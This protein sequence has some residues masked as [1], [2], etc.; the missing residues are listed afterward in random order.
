MAIYKKNEVDL[1]TTYTVEIDYY[2]DD[3]VFNGEYLKNEDGQLVYFGL[4]NVDG[5]Y[6]NKLSDV[7]LTNCITSDDNNYTIKLEKVDNT[8][9]KIFVNKP[10]KKLTL[11]KRKKSVSFYYTNILGKNNVL[12]NI[13]YHPKICHYSR[14]YNIYQIYKIS[15]PTFSFNNLYYVINYNGTSGVIDIDV[16]K[17]ASTIDITSNDLDKTFLHDD[18]FTHALPS[19]INNLIYTY[20]S[21]DHT[22]W[23]LYESGYTPIDLLSKHYDRIFSVNT[24]FSSLRGIFDYKMNRINGTF[25]SGDDGYVYFCAINHTNN[26]VVP[27]FKMNGNTIIERNKNVPEDTY[28]TYIIK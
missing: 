22:Y 8:A 10:K 25:N 2:L 1:V 14:I 28:T 18:N 24:D 20:Y 21:T 12:F 26:T 11:D 16:L 3:T 13:F 9:A 17:T 15:T 6:L 27:V 23:Y 5:D 7:D 4:Q 19:N